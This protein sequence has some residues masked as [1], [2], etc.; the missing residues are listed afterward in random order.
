MIAST[1]H[2]W[3]ILNPI[4]P[5]VPSRMMRACPQLVAWIDLYRFLFHMR[6][7]MC[8]A[9]LSLI[10]TSLFPW[11]ITMFPYRPGIRRFRRLRIYKRTLLNIMHDSRISLI[12]Q[13][14][15]LVFCWHLPT[16]GGLIECMIAQSGLREHWLELV[17]SD[18][19]DKWLFYERGVGVLHFRGLQTFEG[20][21][22]W[23]CVGATRRRKGVVRVQMRLLRLMQVNH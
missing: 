5:C 6:A 18:F 3:V 10:W 8:P 19:G 4:P 23:E 20:Q 13:C 21:G 11:I 14:W 7:A 22:V 1:P 12:D 9:P 2:G 17:G 16:T 15:L